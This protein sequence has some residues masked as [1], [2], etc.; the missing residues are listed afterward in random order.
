MNTAPSV[1]P[2]KGLFSCH[3]AENAGSVVSPKALIFF[4][5]QVWRPRWPLTA[6]N[7]TAIMKREIKNLQFK[8]K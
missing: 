4:V 3:T 8:A 6:Y 1:R 2:N 5:I 7:D